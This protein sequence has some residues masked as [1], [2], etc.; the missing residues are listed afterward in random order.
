MSERDFETEV[1]DALHRRVPTMDGASGLP[2]SVVRRVRRRRVVRAAAS[3][4][5]VVA[6][7]GAG[8]FAGA[9]IGAGEVGGPGRD[10]ATA[11]STTRALQAA[12]GA[13]STTPRALRDDGEVRER[14]L[15]RELD[16]DAACSEGECFPIS[17]PDRD[18][19]A[20]LSVATMRAPEGLVL[21][22]GKV[23]DSVT[24]VR[25][26]TPDGVERTEDISD[27][28]VEEDVDRGFLVVM[29]SDV[30]AEMTVVASDASGAQL[31]RRKVEAPPADG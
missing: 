24:Q 10:V 7:G 21:V 17:I 20:Y 11:T 5:A 19:G 31:E 22:Y 6:L 28:I 25:V 26:S 18:A 9:A 13:V 12:S 2:A 8:M 29:P 27:R 4:V 14:S 30:A 1:A 3:S 23:H 15:P 16:E